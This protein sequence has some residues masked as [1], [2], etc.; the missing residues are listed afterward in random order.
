VAGSPGRQEVGLALTHAVVE[1]ENVGEVI[2]KAM[3]VPAAVVADQV[4]PLALVG[5]LGD[6]A[7]RGAC[8]A[9]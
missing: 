4:E 2:A 3:L 6:D 9:A 7:G 5:R 1:D 8:A